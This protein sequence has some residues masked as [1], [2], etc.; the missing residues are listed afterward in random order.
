[1]NERERERER[2]VWKT[3]LFRGWIKGWGTGQKHEIISL[4]PL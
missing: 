4:K 1:M 3:G 2:R